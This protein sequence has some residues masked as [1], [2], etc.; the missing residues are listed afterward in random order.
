MEIGSLRAKDSETSKRT[1]AEGFLRCV[2]ARPEER[3]AGKK[4]AATSVGMTDFCCGDDVWK[5]QGSC[6][7]RVVN[8]DTTVFGWIRSVSSFALWDKIKKSQP[9]NVHVT[10]ACSMP[11]TFVDVLNS[12]TQAKDGFSFTQPTVP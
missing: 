9:T 4:R 3:D 6:P 12:Y 7:I 10:M 11:Q 2:A 8:G 1:P 5:H